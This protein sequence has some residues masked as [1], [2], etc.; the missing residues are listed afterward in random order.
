MAGLVVHKKLDRFG[1]LE[2]VL[3]NPNNLV[4]ISGPELQPNTLSSSLSVYSSE[5]PSLSKIIKDHQS[6]VASRLIMLKKS[7]KNTY[8]K[9]PTS[10][11]R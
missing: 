5:E 11:T 3:D 2:N 8:S 1:F 7:L 6:S 4:F 10:V 9:L